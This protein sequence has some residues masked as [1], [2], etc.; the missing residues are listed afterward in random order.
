MWP[1][2]LISTLLAHDNLLPPTDTQGSLRCHRCVLC[3]TSSVIQKTN[4]LPHVVQPA[5]KCWQ[6]QL[7]QLIYGSCFLNCVFAGTYLEK[8]R[9]AES[10]WN[11]NNY[12][13]LSIFIWIF[14][15]YMLMYVCDRER[16]HILW[17]M[18]QRPSAETKSWDKGKAKKLSMWCRSLIWL[19]GSQLP[20]A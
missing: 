12:C 18:P 20:K 11:S 4:T 15:L 3:N 6:N 14:N 19:A 16:T 13:F 9:P 1:P 2:L 7:F 8:Y 10:N 5:T 17:L